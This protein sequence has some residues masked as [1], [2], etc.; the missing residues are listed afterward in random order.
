MIWTKILKALRDAG[1]WI[2]ELFVK[3][4]EGLKKTPKIIL[5]VLGALVAVGVYLF[6][7]YTNEKRRAEVARKLATIEKDHADN[8]LKAVD[9]NEEEKKAI[10]EEFEAEKKV[11]E[12]EA[13][14]LEESIRK[15]PSGIAAAWN[16]YLASKNK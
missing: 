11:I 1:S 10:K 4:W 16:E 5:G 13:E 8:V 9:K 7:R 6:T 14:I 2:K 3:L 15:G 12:K